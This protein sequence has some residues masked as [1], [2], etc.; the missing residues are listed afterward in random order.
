MPARINP[1]SILE[2]QLGINFDD[3]NNSFTIFAANT[4]AK[5]MDQF[6]PY[7]EGTLRQYKVQGNLIIYD[8]PYAKY[9]YY[10]MREDGTHVVKN[11]TTPGTGNYWD[12]R[13]WSAK[14]NEVIGT[15]QRELARRSK[16]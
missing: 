2:T 16:E 1:T 8:Q 12:R 10:G 6:V 14:K 11:Y 7:N 15:L 13:M 4:C 5:A 3:P 9:Q